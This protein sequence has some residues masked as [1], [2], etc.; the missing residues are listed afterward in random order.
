M[1]RIGSYEMGESG[2]EDIGSVTHGA[3]TLVDEFQ[4]SAFVK[5]EEVGDEEA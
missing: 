4:F 1:G 3:A 2:R 5:G